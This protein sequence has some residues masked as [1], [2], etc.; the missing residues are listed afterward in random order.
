M[1]TLANRFEVW[2][3]T[4]R[5]IAERPLVGHGW[6]DRTFQSLYVAR[7]PVRSE[8]F[9]HAH[10]L[11]LQVA[12]GVGVVGLALYLAMFSLVVRDLWR[13]RVA[14][15]RAEARVAGVLL[16]SLATT[17]V[18]CLADV[19]RGP[20]HLF[21]WMLWAVGVALTGRRDSGA[22]SATRA[23]IDGDRQGTGEVTPLTAAA[24]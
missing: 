14:G 2:R 13:R 12:F 18:F 21:L 22:R 6:G 1:S 19:P 15:D 4:V 5:M 11:P 10:D 16:L 9:P 3:G 17:A 20:F 23:S 8:D 7:N 24:S